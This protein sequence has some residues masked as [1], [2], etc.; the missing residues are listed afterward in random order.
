[1]PRHK[2]PWPTAVMTMVALMT[3][4]GCDNREA[5]IAREAADR[6]AR[7]NETMATLQQEVAAGT[8]TLADNDA[9]ARQQSFEVHRDL[10]SERSELS[11]QWQNLE[12]Q[13]QEVAHDRR[14]E[15]FLAALVSSGGTTLAVL[16]A[17]AFAWLALFGLHREEASSPEATVLLVEQLLDDSLRLNRPDDE[18]ALLADSS[19]KPSLPHLPETP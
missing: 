5:E 18:R 8:R 12:D 3:T 4:L 13:R 19:P 15:S 10:Q 14:T 7:Q 9:R 11:H 17:L 6:Q 16:F 1:M 2:I